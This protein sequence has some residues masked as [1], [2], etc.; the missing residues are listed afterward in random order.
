MHERLA[1]KLQTT[2]A[3]KWF[4]SRGAGAEASWIAKVE[5]G[6]NWPPSCRWWLVHHGN[7]RLSDECS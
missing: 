4:P 3:F 7:A 6:F 5:L 2:S 1:D